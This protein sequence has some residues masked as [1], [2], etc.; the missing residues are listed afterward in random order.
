MIKL[1][2]QNVR[3]LRGDCKRREVFYLMRQ[4]AEI[5]C[6]QETH[7]DNEV[8]KLWEHEW[9]GTSVWSNANSRTRGV[10]ILVKH[11]SSIEILETSIDNAGRYIIINFKKDDEKYVLTNVYAPNTDS[12]DFF[13][14]IFNKIDNL[15]GHRMLVG[16]F[17][18]VLDPHI[19]RLGSL[20]NNT[21]ACEVLKEYMQQN[22]LCDLWR[23][24]NPN[25]KFYSWRRN[26][27]QVGS[28]LDML[29][30]PTGIANWFKEVTLSRIVKSDHLAISTEFI[31][32]NSERGPGIWRLNTTLLYSK[33]FVDH[34]SSVIDRNINQIEK[35]NFT[36][37]EKWE[38]LKLAI[39]YYAKDFARELA[40]R[41]N[42]NIEQLNKNI[43]EYQELDNP[44]EADTEL[45]EKNIEDL[46][47][48]MQEKVRAA[49]Y[50]TK[51]TWYNES[52]KPTKY[53]YNLESARSRAKQMNT[54]IDRS[55][56]EI[57]DSKDILKEIKN[58]YQDLYTKDKTIQFDEENTS[59]VKLS[60]D[61]SKQLEGLI[62]Y[63]ELSNAAKQ[64]KHDKA[65]GGDGL[66]IEVYIVFWGKLS[67]YLLE[68]LNEAFHTGKLH[69]SALYGV[70]SLLPKK[71]K[72]TRYIANMRP[73][74]LLNTD[75]KLL[76][77]VLANRL[78]PA[79]ESLIHEDQKGFLKGRQI[80]INIRRVLDLV[81][82]T[83]QKGSEQSIA[84]LSIDAEKCFDKIDIDSLIN[85]MKYF[86][87]GK[88]FITWTRL[89]FTN[90]R[91]VV[92]NNGFR[93]QEITVSRGVKQ[94]G[95]CSA[96]YFLLI[97][98][99]LAI[100]LRTNSTIKG[101]S[102]GDIKKILGQYADDTDL[103]LWGDK[104][105][106]HKAIKVVQQFKKLTGFTINIQ[107][108]SLL[109]LGAAK[110]DDMLTKLDINIKVTEKI[111]VL[112]VEIINE[113][114]DTKLGKINYDGLLKKSKGILNNWSKRGLSIIGKVLIVNT[115][116]ASLFVYK[117]SV[118]PAI[119]DYVIEQLEQDITRF[120]WNGNRPKISLK[121]LQM[122][123]SEGGLGLVDFRLKDDS[124]KVKWLREINNDEMICYFSEKNLCSSLKQDIWRCNISA[125]DVETTF[126]KS[127]WRDVLLSWSKLNYGNFP[128]NAEEISNQIIW[129]NSRIKQQGK[130]LIFRK[131]METGLMFIHQILQDDGC[132]LPS[133]DLSQ[134]YN[135][136]T[137]EANAIISAIPRD[138][139]NVL[140]SGEW[141]LQY[142]HYYNYDK[143]TEANKMSKY[144]YHKVNSQKSNVPQLYD[145]WKFLI[146]DEFE[147]SRRP[148]RT[149]IDVR[150]MLNYDLFS[151]VF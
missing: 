115:L 103:Y 121:V 6:L 85:V 54:L 94:G 15:D 79:L 112:G 21:K 47:T 142:E 11:G 87:I 96:Y 61:E 23:I 120:I 5:I 64:I 62:S 19:D 31:A 139:K 45:Y 130:V 106:I 81:E 89:C 140:K 72:D 129:Y 116:I 44:T 86:N 71:N 22:A 108:T 111:N 59:N 126:K 146:G 98:E 7:C 113:K 136:T 56:V 48:L 27:S 114:N 50:R 82:H 147:K 57:T 16:D 107:K 35:S 123:K 51:C 39:M 42:E 145:K 76:E 102:L 40:S 26:K 4:K 24:R 149:F 41:K 109:R 143:I 70:I 100:K 77:K 14:E 119:P 63:K 65:P 10:A 2:S 58:F 66:P 12:P 9:G 36:A 18:L 75:Y 88:D 127:F 144:Y 104:T 8:Q 91:A 105:N 37:S 52:E 32:K 95:C 13:T 20:N 25:R 137:M 60:E 141:D 132:I 90:T 53:F 135:L 93:S 125:T 38:H 55:G 134:K 138:W 3:G 122:E 110:L 73:I 46:E 151:I 150:T 28:R 69:N 118:L 33:D 29:I 17:N 92:M 97:A 124:L 34:I 1:I 74:T 83:E 117:M 101:I 78:K 131:A 148:L 80:S 133:S 49:I 84:I 128:E 43:A 99:L 68:A 30:V 67:K